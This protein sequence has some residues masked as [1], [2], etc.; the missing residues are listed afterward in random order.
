MRALL[1]SLLFLTACA[2][3]S[4]TDLGELTGDGKADVQTIKVPL[5]LAGGESMEFSVT[6]DARFQVKATY[7]EDALVKIAAGSSET[8]GVQPTLVVDAPT[9]PTDFVLTVTNTSAAALSGTL[10]V[11]AAAPA[12][13][14]DVWVPWFDALVKKID[15]AGDV[16]DANDR[17]GIDVL[18]SGRPCQ[19]ST[20]TAFI[21]WDDVY[22][23][24]ITAAGDVI[25]AADATRI[26]LI[27]VHRPSAETEAA[28][29]AWLPKFTTALKAAGE[30]ID[31]SDK[32]KID[33]RLSVRPKATTDKGY[34]AWLQG[35]A[36]AVIAA[37]AVI[38]ANDTTL[39]MTNLSGKPCATGTPEALEAWNKLAASAPG[40]AASLVQAAS[41]TAGCQ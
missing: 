33:L 8:S 6:V 34:I 30:V 27:K 16:I 7:P 12:C 28:Y 35:Y 41:P 20:D 14:D 3:E 21:H 2:S 26:D 36:T 15:D 22:E 23:A 29:L 13:G 1:A 19:S 31:S 17:A 10:E 37:G 4:I 40:S 25:D 5:R 11:G 18:A 32:T 39:L 9:T 38:D 24:K